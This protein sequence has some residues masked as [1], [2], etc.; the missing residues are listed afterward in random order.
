MV[1]EEQGRTVDDKYEE[2][3]DRV[4]VAVVVVEREEEQDYIVENDKLSVQNAVVD[5]YNPWVGQKLDWGQRKTGVGFGCMRFHLFDCLVGM[6]KTLS[7]LL[8]WE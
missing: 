1:D 5:F 7:D 6:D 4:V 2:G 8:D 3:W